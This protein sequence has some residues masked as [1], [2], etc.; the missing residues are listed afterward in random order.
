[1]ALTGSEYVRLLR[2][3]V[4]R[5]VAGGRTYDAVIAACV[6]KADADELLTLNRCHFDPVPAGLSIIEPVR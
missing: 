4:H 5:D 1:M 2:D 3:I 6:R